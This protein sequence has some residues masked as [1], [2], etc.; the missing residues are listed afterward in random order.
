MGSARRGFETARAPAAIDVKPVNRRLAENGR[1]IRRHIDD[2]APFAQHPHAIED[3]ENLDDGR[4]RMLDQ[5]QAAA[6]RIGCILVRARTNNQL[7][8]VGLAD[9]GVDRIRHDNAGE[10]RLDRL[11]HQRLQRIAFE[12]Q[13]HAGRVHNN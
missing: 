2:T 9:I 10:D 7:A 6:L 11:R 1:A 5:R 8:L 4:D 12:R 3:R 13:A